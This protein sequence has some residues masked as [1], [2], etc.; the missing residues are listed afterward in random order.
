[1]VLCSLPRDMLRT[2]A[3]IREA[4]TKRFDRKDPPVTLRR[5]LSEIR[6]KQESNEEFGE[7]IR[8]L[9]T[10]VYPG[11]DV[12]MQD[13]LAAEAFLK[14]YKNTKIAY[15]VLNKKP[16]TLN[17][18][19][20]MVTFQEHNFKATIG[21]P[22][23]LLKRDNARRVSWIDEME[24]DEDV[25]VRRMN[26]QV[27]TTMDELDERLR[28]F[29]L[30][31]AQ[32]QEKSLDR[33]EKL[34]GTK[35]ENKGNSFNC[36]GSGHFARNC[37]ERTRSP[38]PG[39]TFPA[40]KNINV[41]GVANG[42]KAMKVPV[43]VNGIDTYAVIDTG[44]DATIVSE[45]VA[46]E[47]RI[48]VPDRSTRSRLLVL[49]ATNDSEMIA[50][51]GVTATIQLANHVY[52]WKVFVAPIRDPILL[53]LDFMKFINAIIYTGQGDV[54]IDVNIIT[55]TYLDNDQQNANGNLVVDNNIITPAISNEIFLGRVVNHVPNR[56]SSQRSVPYS[57]RLKLYS[58]D[59]FPGWSNRILKK[60]TDTNLA[61][62]DEDNV[63]LPSAM[64]DITAT[65]NTSE[66]EEDAPLVTSTGPKRTSAR[67][68]DRNPTE[69]D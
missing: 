57:D 62:L 40:Q 32:E 36:Q 28:R 39:P 15:D 41:S 18:A 30:K 46:T 26:S 51:G 12:V 3:A 4:L 68:N 10:R 50:I 19:L 52:N 27:Y 63:L 42:G 16:T 47:A 54:A 8:R 56:N 67:P 45:K 1:M 24:S 35:A 69:I 65:R 29:E 49:N 55:S 21:R 60:I 6:Q 25:K 20:E 17:E 14:G 61:T 11:V 2:F 59:E 31:F 7:E 48:I 5:M 44:A 43:S 33:I 34:F 38:S 64:E 13:Q 9:V 23:E 37:P 58:S 22:R 53:G 66:A